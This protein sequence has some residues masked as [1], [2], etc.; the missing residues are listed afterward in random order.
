MTTCELRGLEFNHIL[1][2][3]SRTQSSLPNVFPNKCYDT[4]P[5]AFVLLHHY[6]LEAQNNFIHE[7]LPSL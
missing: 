2:A 1:K 4:L 7:V 5:F 6:H 3:W